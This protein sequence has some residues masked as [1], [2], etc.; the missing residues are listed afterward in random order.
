MIRQAAF[1][2]KK[3]ILK[4]A[5]HCHTTRSDGAGSPESVVR[6]HIDNGFGFMAITDH[7]LYNYENFAKDASIIIVP[8]MEIDRDIAG[9]HGVHCF[10]TVAIGPSRNAGNPYEQNQSFKTGTVRDQFEFQNTLDQL[11][12]DKQMTIYCHPQ[13]SSTP[14]REFERLTGNFAM[15]IWN[16]GCAIENEMDVNAAYWDELLMQNIR[17]WGAAVDDGH[18]M[19]HHCKGW[20]CVNSDPELSAILDAL[21][22]GAFYS[23]CGPEIHDFYVDK[24]TAVV[25]CSPCQSISFHYGSHPTRITHGDNGAPVKCAKFT[26]PDRFKYIR[27][28]VKDE[29][30]RRAWTN[31]IFF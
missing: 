27:A 25:E 12:C 16:S 24:G 21:K 9:A 18:A 14:A 8:G 4:G 11:H 19:D 23:S 2:N 10:H 13:W 30:G 26:V 31:P 17:I 22:S 1:E 5:L 6:K 3:A 28:S 20:V 29:Q 15:E 7:R